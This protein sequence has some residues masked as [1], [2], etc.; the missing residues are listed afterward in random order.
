MLV[1]DQSMVLSVFSGTE[2]RLK[3]ESRAKE[4]HLPNKK[5]ANAKG[6]RERDTERKRREKRREERKN[7]QQ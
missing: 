5:S 4:L 3:M 2:L 6:E 1:C 7:S